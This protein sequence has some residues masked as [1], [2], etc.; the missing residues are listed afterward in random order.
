MTHILRRDGTGEPTQ[1]EAAMVAP[2]FDPSETRS[3]GPNLRCRS[4]RTPELTSATLVWCGVPHGQN[5][6]DCRQ[7]ER[8]VQRQRQARHVIQ[9]RIVGMVP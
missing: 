5:G 4:A 1:N 3:S 9:P 2:G 8:G 7:K 6:G